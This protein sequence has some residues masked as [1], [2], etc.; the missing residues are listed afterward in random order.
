MKVYL[1]QSFDPIDY[2]GYKET[3]KIFSNKEKA[4]E[5]IE[6]DYEEYVIFNKEKG[7]EVCKKETLYDIEEWSVE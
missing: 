2:H 3:L 1:V 4:E 5:F 7:W 6:K